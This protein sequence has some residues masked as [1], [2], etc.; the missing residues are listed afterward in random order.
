M[1]FVTKRTQGRGCCQI[2]MNGPQLEENMAVVG[3][4]IILLCLFR[5]FACNHLLIMV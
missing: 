5:G 3:L 2:V 1:L 4:R